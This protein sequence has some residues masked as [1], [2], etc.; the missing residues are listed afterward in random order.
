[1]TTTVYF[2]VFIPCIYWY[3][4]CVCVCVNLCSLFIWCTFF[5]V[6][7]H[8]MYNNNSGCMCVCTFLRLC[9]RVYFLIRPV[10]MLWYCNSLVF[11]G[12]LVNCLLLIINSLC[13]WS[14]VKNEWIFYWKLFLQIS[15]KI[16]EYCNECFTFSV[17]IE[18]F[19][20]E[21]IK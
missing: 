20:N 10:L 14:L 21:F 7:R 16:Y 18:K 15:T 8:D 6:S 19:I 17:Y 1:M 13:K 2:A 12:Y 5:S 3:Y 9:A 11:V 4:L